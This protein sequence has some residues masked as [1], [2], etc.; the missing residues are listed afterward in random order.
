MGVQTN[1][2]LDKVLPQEAGVKVPMFFS[3]SESFK[4]PQFNPLDPDI[5]FK[6]ALAN[7][8]D[9]EERDSIRFAGQEYNMQKSLNFTN[10]RKEKGSGGW[11]RTWAREVL[12]HNRWV[13]KERN[14]KRRAKRRKRSTSK[15][16]LGQFSVCHQ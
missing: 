3:F 15:N 12:V 14:P 1:V 16:K 4:S 11:R 9:Q 6:S 10:V 7:V 8:S 5:E 13:R 2:N